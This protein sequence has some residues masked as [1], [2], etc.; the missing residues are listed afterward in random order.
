MNLRNVSLNQEFYFAHPKSKVK[1]NSIYNS[2]YTGCQLW[3]LF[4]NGALKYEGTY[5]RSVKIMFDLPYATHR[6]FIEHLT[7][8]PHMKKTLIQRYLK[9]IKSMER[10]PKKSLQLLLN[11]AKNDV[12]SVTGSNLRQ[13]MLLCEKNSV[14]DL[15]P[16]DVNHF[17]QCSIKVEVIS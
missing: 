10:S 5:N 4:G 6:F 13:I 7:E 1:L 3:N 14:S 11:I 8:K 17:S 15:G 16:L 2:H 9:F 12:R